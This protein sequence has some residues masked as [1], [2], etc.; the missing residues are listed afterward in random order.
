VSTSSALRIRSR[1]ASQ[2]DFDKVDFCGQLSV[3]V[4]DCHQFEVCL[5]QS[6]ERRLAPMSQL[7]STLELRMKMLTRQFLRYSRVVTV[8]VAL[9]SAATLTALPHAAWAA[10][11]VPSATLPSLQLNDQQD[12]PVTVPPSTRWLLFAN[13][14][15]VSDMVSAVFAAEPFGVLDRLHLVYVADISAMPALVTRM[16]ALPKLRELPFPIGLVRESD[17]LAQT[18]NLP[19]QPGAATLLRVTD[20]RVIE[21]LAVRN[22]AELRAAL[23]LPEQ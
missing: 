4:D 7:E 15:A 9:M 2:L 23:V 22:S 18:A 13:E 1:A 12:K 6:E 8:L 10:P 16:F 5:A 20:G 3:P 21:I 17:Q 14:T 19:R 11:L